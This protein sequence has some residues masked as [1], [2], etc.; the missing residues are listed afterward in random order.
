M[1][2]LSK[3]G[4][5]HE[6]GIDCILRSPNRE[7]PIQ[8]VR[9]ISNPSYRKTLA[10]EKALSAES[11]NDHI[12]EE[13][14][15]SIEKKT[16]RTAAKGRLEMALVLD[17]TETPQCAAAQIVQGFRD[18]HLMWVQSLGYRAVWLVGRSTSLVF[19]LDKGD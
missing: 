9:A 2:D 10:A 12:I 11:E 19:R 3:L 13:L 8:V 15:K 4:G 18:K 16:A 6:V 5:A 7:L 14:Q 1:E 17:A